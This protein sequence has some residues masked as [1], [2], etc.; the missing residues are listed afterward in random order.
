MR[1][2]KRDWH[3]MLPSGSEIE[4]HY[5]HNTGHVRARRRGGE[6]RETEEGQQATKANYAEM[7]GMSLILKKDEPL[8][9]I[10]LRRKNGK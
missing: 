5:C 3:S 2:K 10:V 7:I 8:G 4:I 6:W 1:D 9:S